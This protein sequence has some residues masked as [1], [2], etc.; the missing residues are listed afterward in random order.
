[1]SETNRI[2]R[3]APNPNRM[4]VEQAFDLYIKDQVPDYNTQTDKERR[5]VRKSFF[6]GVWLG[7][8][9][10]NKVTDLRNERLA[11]EVLSDIQAEVQ[12]VI[13]THRNPKGRQRP[14]I[15]LPEDV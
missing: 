6:T 8:Q 10:V 11:R 2:E 15:I 13:S 4:L 9:Y 3:P 5:E 1:M 7:F 12:V 14:G